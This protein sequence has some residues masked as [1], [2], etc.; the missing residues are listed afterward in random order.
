MNVRH[1]LGGEIYFD[2]AKSA[3]YQNGDL[4][5]IPKLIPDFEVAAHCS[6]ICV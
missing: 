4:Q 5:K 3:P 2:V 1:P 6:I